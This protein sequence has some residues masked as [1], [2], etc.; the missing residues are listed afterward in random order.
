MA[1]IKNYRM[2]KS[3]MRLISKCTA[4]FKTYFGVMSKFLDRAGCF[5]F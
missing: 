3:K 2:W 4:L 5:T 1:I